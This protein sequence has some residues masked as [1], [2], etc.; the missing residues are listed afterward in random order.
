MTDLND[1]ALC[2]DCGHDIDDHHG[3]RCHF[4]ACQCRGFVLRRE[5]LE[6]KR[7]EQ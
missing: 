4:P 6:Q 7:E 3:L 5:L 2:S 1:L